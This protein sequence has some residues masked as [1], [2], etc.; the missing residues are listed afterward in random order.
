MTPNYDKLFQTS[1]IPDSPQTGRILENGDC[2]EK[3]KVA[4]EDEPKTSTRRLFN[5]PNVPRSALQ[6]ILKRDL[7]LKP[8]RSIKV[9]FLSSYNNQRRIECCQAILEKYTSND[10]SR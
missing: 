6:R 1:G 10:I 7:Q 8:W 2:F 5:E 9:Q 4:I 3:I